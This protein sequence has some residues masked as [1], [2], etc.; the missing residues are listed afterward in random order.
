MRY[1]LLN[2]GELVEDGDEEYSALDNE[3]AVELE[4]WRPVSVNF[5][6]EYV[7]EIDPPVRRRIKLS[8]IPISPV[9]V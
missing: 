3:A 1:I 5:I 9:K 4:R 2:V 8:K 6:G 7:Q